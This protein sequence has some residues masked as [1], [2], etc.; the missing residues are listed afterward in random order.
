MCVV[1]RV[2]QHSGTH[3]WGHVF[4]FRFSVV[5]VSVIFGYCCC[6]FWHSLESRTLCSL[7]IF[8]PHSHSFVCLQK[9]STR[10]HANNTCHSFNACNLVWLTMLQ[11]THHITVSL[12][13]YIYI[14]PRWK[15]RFMNIIFED[16]I[17]L[18]CEPKWYM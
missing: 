1:C 5:S 3:W 13:L 6:Y 10:C 2:Y 18:E 8:F 16:W 12:S 4:S 9:L 14:V 7:L 15:T 17:L 11:H